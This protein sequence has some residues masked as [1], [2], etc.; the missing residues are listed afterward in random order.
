MDSLD[1]E[2]EL[3]AEI[4]PKGREKDTQGFLDHRSRHIYNISNDTALFLQIG[5]KLGPF[6]AIFHVE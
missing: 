1:K 6:M 2:S 4:D 3:D 5:V